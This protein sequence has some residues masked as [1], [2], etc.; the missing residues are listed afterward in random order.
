MA[1]GLKLEAALNK[2]DVF[3]IIME[4]NQPLKTVVA[5]IE[6]DSSLNIVDGKY[7]DFQLQPYDQIFVRTIPKFSLQKYINITGEVAYPGQYALIEENEKLSS[8]ITRAGGFNTEAFP[9]G[10]TLYRPQEN[11]GFIIVKMDEILNNP[12][13]NS[14]LVLKEGDVIDIPKTKDIVSIKGATKASELYLSRILTN[15]TVNVAFDGER[16][17]WY[18]VDKYAAGVNN[19]GRKKLIVVEQPNGTIKRTKNYFFFK[20]YPKVEKGSTITVGYAEK[21]PE[22]DKT[23]KEKTDW[24]KILSDTLAQTVALLSFILLIERL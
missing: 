10:T 11:I 16:S 22:K 12:G 4:D 7:K 24:G 17:A 20:V 2:V 1:N 19:D 5:T 8:A 14:N 3:R 18:Y 13:S 6:V 23:P 21:K 15:G 9:A